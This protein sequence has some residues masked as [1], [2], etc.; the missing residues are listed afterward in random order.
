MDRYPLLGWAWAHCR[1]RYCPVHPVPP[2]RCTNEF[3]AAL[4]LT[5]SNSTMPLTVRLDSFIGL[6]TV[7]RQH[8]S[9]ASMVATIRCWSCSR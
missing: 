9:G 7:D 5:T 8:L 4:T 6:Y 2:G 3:I 1:P